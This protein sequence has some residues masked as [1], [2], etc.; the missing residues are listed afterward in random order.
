VTAPRDANP[1]LR[2]RRVLVGPAGCRDR[3]RTE[4]IDDGC[5]ETTMSL[6]QEVQQICLEIIEME[7]GEIGLDQEFLSFSHIDSLKALDI[8]TALER[9]YRV[10]IP[11]KE[12]R[13]FTT[14]NAVIAVAQRHVAARA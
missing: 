3:W 6:E 1:K 10:K 7:P 14:I 4:W 2:A 8:L 11:E 9:K 12:L 13:E 5:V